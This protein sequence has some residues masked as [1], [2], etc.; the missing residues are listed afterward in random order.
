MA[1]G[2]VMTDPLPGGTT[3]VSA[4]TSVGSCSTPTVGA[5]GT[6]QCNLGILSAGASATFT[7]VVKVRPSLLTLA[8]FTNKATVSADTFDPN[9]ANNTATARTTVLTVLNN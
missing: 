3:F 6:V 5:G 9:T 2:V 1:N 8:T 7:V 4:S